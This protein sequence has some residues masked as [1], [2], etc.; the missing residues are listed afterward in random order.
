MQQVQLGGDRDK[1]GRRQTLLDCGRGIDDMGLGRETR[2]SGG[3]EEAPGLID[4]VGGAEL[5]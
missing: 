2:V 4:G 1:E 5:R 3:R